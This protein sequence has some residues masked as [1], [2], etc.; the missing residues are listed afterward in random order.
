MSQRIRHKK[1]RLLTIDFFKKDAYSTLTR[2]SF[3]RYVFC[4]ELA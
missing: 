1:D 2:W 3:R 4:K